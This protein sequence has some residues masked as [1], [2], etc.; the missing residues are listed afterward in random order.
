[1][2]VYRH[3]NS[4]AG[5]EA[6]TDDASVTFNFWITEDDA[7]LDSDHGGLVVY[8][9]EQP[10]D[11]DWNNINLRK[12]APDVKARIANFLEDAEAVTIPHR[13]NRAVLFHS[14]LFHMS[15][16][17]NFL[18]GFQNRR[19]NITLLFGERGH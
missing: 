17:F 9:K 8:A 16:R 10:L 6:H 15:D 11:W 1:M 14:N 2:W 7:K 13:A 5:V 19:T 12:N 3:R 4:G 18:D